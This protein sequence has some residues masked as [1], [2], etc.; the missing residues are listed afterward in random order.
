[1]GKRSLS[2]A[3]EAEVGALMV[4]YLDE[5]VQGRFI[6]EED[7]LHRC[8]SPTVEDDLKARLPD[9]HAFLQFRRILAAAQPTEN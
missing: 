2:Y 9:C 6:S 5:A 8:S 3:E 4:E 7:L 1:M